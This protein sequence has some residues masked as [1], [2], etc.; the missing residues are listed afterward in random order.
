MSTV[1]QT[2]GIVSNATQALEECKNISK[3]EGPD[4]EITINCSKAANETIIQL[5][6]SNEAET[7][8]NDYSEQEDE[9]CLK[10]LKSNLLSIRTND[11]LVSMHDNIDS[12]EAKVVIVRLPVEL[13]LNLH[14][15]GNV[16]VNEC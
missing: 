13:F 9:I 10:S 12:K 11:T 5:V 7:F 8:V 4:N 2:N 14:G 1:Q 3:I 15:K 6:A 16:N